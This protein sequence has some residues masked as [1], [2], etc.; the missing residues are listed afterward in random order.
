MWV[1]VEERLPVQTGY[2][3][4]KCILED[5]DPLPEPR[6]AIETILSIYFANGSFAY[7]PDTTTI[8]AWQE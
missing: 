5:S 6:S 4:C 3:N 1:P 8:I 2:Y 7:N